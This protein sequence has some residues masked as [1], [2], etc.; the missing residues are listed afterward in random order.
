MTLIALKLKFP[1]RYNLLILYNIYEISISVILIT[2]KIYIIL[3]P[4]NYFLKI[5]YVIE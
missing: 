5:E 4:E 3:F 1:H 2:A